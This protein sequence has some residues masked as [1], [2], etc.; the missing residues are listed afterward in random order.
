VPEHRQKVI[1]RLAAWYLR[2]CPI[3]RGRGLVNRLLGRFLEV[4]TLGDIRIRLIN[5][6]EYHQRVLLFGVPY[7]PEVTCFLTGV[8]KPGMVFIDVGANL[9]YYTLLGAKRV[10]PHGQVHSFE[11]APLQ[12]R[13][14]TLNVETNQIANVV[15]NNCAVADRVGET[16]LFMSDGWNQGT[17][18][19][20]MAQ[21]NMRECRVKCTSLDEYVAEAGLCHVDVVKIDVEGAELLVCRGA[22]RTLTLLKPPVIVFEACEKWTQALSHSTSHVKEFLEGCGYAIYR[23]EASSAPVRTRP[24]TVE[25]YANLVGI[26]TTAA[27]FW[28]E[29]LEHAVRKCLSEKDLVEEHG[30]ERAMQ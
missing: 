1:A 10:G 7:E 16:Q 17:H 18:S 29:Q 23:L 30:N 19:L 9:G 28:Y 22:S 6:L 27:G 21:G 2:D 4:Q 11:P 24:S 12:F 25:I 5:P 20:G 8:L 13:H 15:L 26:H 14:L 3:V